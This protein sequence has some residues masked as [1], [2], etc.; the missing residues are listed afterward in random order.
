M[1]AVIEDHF[2]P[3]KHEK[4]V[5]SIH[6]LREDAE[7]ALELKA[8]EKNCHTW[9]CGCRVV[10]IKASNVM[11]GKCITTDKFSTWAPGETDPCEEIYQQTD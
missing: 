6:A 7:R 1:Y 3:E 8:K 10:W 5:H 9:E 2:N 4:Y 11:P